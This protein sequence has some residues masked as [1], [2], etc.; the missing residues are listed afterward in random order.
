MTSCTLPPSASKPYQ[1]PLHAGGRN[2]L[3]ADTDVIAQVEAAL[4]RAQGGAPFSTSQVIILVKAW[5][6]PMMEIVDFLHDLRRAIGSG[7]R[8]L[9]V[10]LQMASDHAAGDSEAEMTFEQWQHKLTT[11]GDPWLQ[12]RPLTLPAEAILT[13]MGSQI[14]ADN[15]E[16][17]DA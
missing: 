12:V 17:P 1:S 14:K 9:V 13:A 10:A 15:Q 5:E 16:A 4:R 6:P 3:E 2:T 7:V 8:I 11:I